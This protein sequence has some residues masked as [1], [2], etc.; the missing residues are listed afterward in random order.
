MTKCARQTYR[1]AGD[2]ETLSNSA[3]CKRESVVDPWNSD[4]YGRRSR[5]VSLTYDV[6]RSVKTPAD[7]ATDLEICSDL[8]RAFFDKATVLANLEAALGMRGKSRTPMPTLGTGAQSARPLR[9]S[10]RFAK[11]GSMESVPYLK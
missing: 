2:R 11:A 5:L 4:E 10:R 8:Y 7:G 6:L 9:A 3:F 1:V